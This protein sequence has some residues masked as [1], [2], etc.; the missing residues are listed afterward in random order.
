MGWRDAA[1]RLVLADV[2]PQRVVWNLEDVPDLFGGD[3]LPEVQGSFPVPRPFVELAGDVVLHSD[4][5]RFALLYR[6]L[7]RVRRTSDLLEDLTDRDISRANLMAKNVRR[8]IHKMH[9][10]VRFRE[11]GDGRMVAWFEPEHHVIEAGAPFF[12]R[13]FPNMEWSILSPY[14]SA[15]WDGA[16]LSFGPGAGRQAAPDGDALEKIWR[17]YYSSIFN[18]ARLK[19]RAM[20]SEMPRKYWRNLPEADLIAPLIANARKRTDTMVA[21]GITEPKSNRQREIPK[22]A[23]PVSEKR[24]TLEALREEARGCRMC[25]LWKP[26]TQTVFGEGPSQA[27]IMFVGEQPG[28]RE[29]LA[30]QPFVGPAGQV[31]DRALQEIGLDRSRAYITNAVKHFKFTPRGKMRLHQKPNAMEIRLCRPWLERE[32]YLVQPKLIVALGATAVQGLF[33][34]ALPI[35]TNRG[36][37]LDLAEAQVLITV[38]PSYL[39]RVPDE[40]RKAEEYARFVEDLTLARDALNAA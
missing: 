13:R 20:Q 16:A 11:A 4:P 29:D 7:W 2:P 30:G 21:H 22:A 32:I 23:P 12:A 38:H 26:A 19:V 25:P 40:G 35:A 10:F 6:I 17:C 5:E 3:E 1:R 24:G 8:D 27:K 28:D 9:A 14:V 34:R 31:F 18:P 15:H 39:L 33:G 36:R 37:F